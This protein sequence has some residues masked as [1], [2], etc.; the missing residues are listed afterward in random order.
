[1]G[2]PPKYQPVAAGRTPTSEGIARADEA[3]NAT[4]LT[5]AIAVVLITDGD[6]NCTWDQAATVGIITA[7]AARGIKTY[8]VGLPGVGGNGMTILTTLATAGGTAPYLTPMDSAQLTA[9]MASIVSSTISVGFNS[10]SIVINP[11]TALP[12]DLQLVVTENG[13]EL[14]V[15]HD[16]GNG[17]GWTIT[18]DGSLVELTGA[19]CTDAKA[20]RFSKLEFKFGCIDIPQLPPPPPPE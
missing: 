17:A 16:L 6:P 18:P 5:G 15:A 8:V 1:M 9:Q 20:G 10:C 11:P 14:G 13:M 2:P 19:L 7:W 3:L 12:N 4:Q